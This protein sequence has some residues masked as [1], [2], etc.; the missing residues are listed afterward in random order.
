SEEDDDGGDERRAVLAEAPPDELPLR[1][2]EDAGLVRLSARGRGDGARALGGDRPAQPRARLCDLRRDVHVVG[3]P[4]TAPTP[5]DA[6]RPSPALLRPRG[7][8]MRIRG[9]SQ[10]R[11]MSE[12]SVPTTVRTLRMK[13]KLPAMYMSLERRARRRRG[14]VIG[15][16]ST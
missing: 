15:R 16:L 14:P 8:L 5:P 7:Q 3:L 9:S 1:G 2:D 12:M 4:P 11:R 13:M 6:P 10:A